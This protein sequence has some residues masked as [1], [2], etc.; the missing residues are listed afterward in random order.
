MAS[1]VARALLSDSYKVIDN[2]DALMATLDGIRQAG[3]EV[4]STAWT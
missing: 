4:P 3:V 1:G 2:L